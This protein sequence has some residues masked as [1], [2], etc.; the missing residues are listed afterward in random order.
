MI[1]LHT[2]LYYILI[3]IYIYKP[4]EEIDKKNIKDIKTTFDE[5]LNSYRQIINASSMFEDLI[6]SLNPYKT[7]IKLIRC[8]AIG[9]FHQDLPARY[10][11]ALLLEIIQYLSSHSTDN[12]NN[13]QQSIT[14]SIYDPI[15]DKDDLDYISTK[16]QKENWKLEESMPFVSSNDL[17]LFFLPHAPL[18]LTETILNIERPKLCLA[19]NIITHTDR[20]TK[21][22]LFEK[23][24]FISKLVHSL[25]S[26]TQPII[27]KD[28]ETENDQ[29]ET[30]I[31]KKNKRRNRN[32]NNK[33]IIY[34]E[35][36]I[37]Y[38][39]IDTYFK[40]CSILTD[41]N[42]GKLLKDIKNTWINSFSDLT[43]HLIE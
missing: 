40:N 13:E 6:N 14:V 32:N 8:L 16:Q 33:H 43:L 30:F 28:I 27:P 25:E 4:S 31:S 29:F 2:C 11:L 7:K 35:P 17:T 18:N 42:N 37:D 24:P 26:T 10:Q 21:L 20:Y 39:S 38:D 9:S 23:Y 36:T 41:F 19:N 15:F 12:N 1:L 34:K 22:Q 3:Y 5:V